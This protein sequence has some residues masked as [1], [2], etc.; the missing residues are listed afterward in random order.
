MKVYRSRRSILLGIFLWAVLLA[1]V[2]GML[3][4]SGSGIIFLAIYSV[5]LAFVGVIWFGIN[6]Q[7]R[8]TILWVMIGPACLYKV[9]IKDIESINRSY[10]PLSSP[11]ASLRRILVKFKGGELLISPKNERGFVQE[12]KEINNSIYC[13]ISWEKENE[14]I[15]TRFVYSIL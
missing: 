8:G 6:Y 4:F 7:V 9:D 12:L 11:A 1:P 13:G 2:F 15:L 5:V 14:S 10:N 3:P